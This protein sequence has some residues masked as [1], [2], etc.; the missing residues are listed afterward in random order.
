MWGTV[1]PEPGR[2]VITIGAIEIDGAAI[3]A[4]ISDQGFTYYDHLSNTYLRI[5]GLPDFTSATFSDAAA[6][7]FEFALGTTP[8][9]AAL[10]LFATGLGAWGLLGWRE[11]KVAA[12]AA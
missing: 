5:T 2:N 10:A 6:S 4:A 11:K 12:L 1:D 7:N 9:P 3:M 8:L